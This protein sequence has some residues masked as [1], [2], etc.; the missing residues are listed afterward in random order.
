MSRYDFWTV[1]DYIALYC[2][3]LYCYVRCGT[4]NDEEQKGISLSD[5]DDDTPN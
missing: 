1:L 5:R 3:V 2:I 4:V